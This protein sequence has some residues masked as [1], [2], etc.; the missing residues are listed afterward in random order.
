MTS[1]AHEDGSDLEIAVIGY[2]CR[3]AGAWSA[4][5]LWMNLREGVDSISS[6]SDDELRAA[7]V[8]AVDLERPGYVKARGILGDA[9]SFDAA[10]FGV[11]PREAEL[12]D[13]QHRHLLECGWE[14]LE[15]AG[16]D[17]AAHRGRVG[18]FVGAGIN[19][20][21]LENLYPRRDLRERSAG[22]ELVMAGD[23]DFL[24]TRMSYKL[25]LRGPSVVVQSACSTSLVAV[26]LACQA[27]L[28]G[29]CDV[30]IAGGA[31]VRA[32]E[33]RGYVH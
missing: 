11:T 18:V 3:S 24:A 26:H 17:A 28:S 13:P 32:P 29:E 6:F 21:L 8:R 16:H 12:L 4:R 10:F 14:A 33:I 20:Y 31:T 5:E 30:A 23:K 19:T 27:L 7:G 15:D 25:D 1:P 9:E 2:A 22:L